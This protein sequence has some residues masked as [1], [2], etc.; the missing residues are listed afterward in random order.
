MFLILKP[1]VGKCFKNFDIAFE[2]LLSRM[3]AGCPPRDKYILFK[4]VRQMQ[5]CVKCG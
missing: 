4:K 2:R 5:K 1:D 3:V